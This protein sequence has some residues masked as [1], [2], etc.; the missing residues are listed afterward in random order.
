MNKKA[1]YKYYFTLTRKSLKVLKH[2]TLKKTRDSKGFSFLQ[3]FKNKTGMSSR[4]KEYHAKG[5]LKLKTIMNKAITCDNN[6][7]MNHPNKIYA[8]DIYF[9][10]WKN[11]TLEYSKLIQFKINK[12]NLLIQLFFRKVRGMKY[13]MQ[14][15]ERFRVISNYKAFL[16]TVMRGK[17]SKRIIQYNQDNFLRNVY[18]RLFFKYMFNHLQNQP[19]IRYVI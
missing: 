8:L 10:R 17:K 16:D 2:F 18:Y 12:R 4:D 14:L 1:L 3:Y 15:S 6:K 19:G 13:Y 9:N 5:L 7:I 11:N